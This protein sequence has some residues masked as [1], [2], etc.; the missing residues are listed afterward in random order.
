MITNKKLKSTRFFAPYS[1]D[2][3]KTQTLK[4]TGAGVY[5]IK[6]NGL[7]VYV[8]RSSAD[9]KS[10]LYRHFQKWT[11]RRSVWGKRNMLYERVTYDGQNRANFT[12]KVIFTPTD[13]EAN[14]IEHMLIL[15]LKPRDNERKNDLYSSENIPRM[16]SRIENE[17][18]WNINNDEPPF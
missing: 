9:V 4:A 12:V 14:V 13:F 3:L 7:V 15:K 18:N 16:Q 6:K 11:D 5:I 17:E 10:T 1:G 2:N 8:G